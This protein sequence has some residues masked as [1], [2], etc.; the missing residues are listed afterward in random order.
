M[1][2]IKK[3]TITV[4]GRWDAP[5]NL[6]AWEPMSKTDKDLCETIKFSL[7]MGLIESMDDAIIGIYKDDL[8]A[9]KDLTWTKYDIEL[10]EV[11]QFK[12]TNHIVSEQLDN[13]LQS[14]DVKNQ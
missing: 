14:N 13:I 12:E 9:P 2:T 5:G 4:I 8:N 1:I 7:I 10:L 11:K 3:I 6:L